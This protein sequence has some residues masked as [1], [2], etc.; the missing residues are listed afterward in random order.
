MT[1]TELA[2]SP[3]RDVFHYPTHTYAWAIL[4]PINED[5]IIGVSVAGKITELRT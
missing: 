4:I 3:S 2:D 1:R 5:T